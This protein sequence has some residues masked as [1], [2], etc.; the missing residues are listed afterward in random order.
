MI[1]FFDS[2]SERGGG[3]VVLEHLL[4][5][6]T[7]RAS[8]SLVMPSQ[9]QAKIAVP[10]SAKSY[11]DAT[12]FLGAAT[13]IPHVLVSNANSAMP[14]VMAAARKLRRR[15]LH[16]RTVAIV[17]NYPSTI[18]YK[19][20]TAYYLKQFDIAIVV[21]PGLL[22]LRSDAIVP[23][24][25]SLHAPL[26]TS[27]DFEATRID[28]TGVVKSYGRPDKEKGLHHLAPIFESLTS[29]GVR[30][31]VALGSGFAGDRK[32]A[33]FLRERLAPWLVDGHRTSDWIHPGDI[34]IIPSLMEAA[35]L[36]AQEAMSKGAFVVATRVG[37]MT[38]LSPTSEGV[39]TFAVGDTKSATNLIKDALDLNAAEFGDECL[40]A[41][42]AIEHRAGRWHR[43]TVDTL[44][45]QLSM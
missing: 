41:V 16:V 25:L 42:A 31:E 37:L 35:C 20:A 11:D 27:A 12:A 26:S 39:R 36:T 33:A 2:K 45:R 34:F 30:C 10:H 4:G 28:R 18:A 24:W 22:R 5:M 32:Y 29:S 38:Y 43:D 7:D 15:G 8:T 19:A 17:H 6:I 9:G 23:S 40:A 3:Q 21:E 13:D 1:T 44:I 14:E